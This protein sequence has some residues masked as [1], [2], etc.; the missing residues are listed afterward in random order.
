MIPE[1][2]SRVPSL[3]GWRRRQ[4]DS[5]SD[6]ESHW[7]AACRSARPSALSRPEA[8]PEAMMDTVFK[9]LRLTGIEISSVSLRDSEST[10]NTLGRVQSGHGVK[11]ASSGVESGVRNL[12][13]PTA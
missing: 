1:Y 9:I 6:W 8:G 4:L 12:P 13:P 5:D 3:P 10:G 2:A 7:Q 11:R